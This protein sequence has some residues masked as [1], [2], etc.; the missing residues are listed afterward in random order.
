MTMAGPPPEVEKRRKALLKKPVEFDQNDFFWAK[1]DLP[2]NAT[3]EVSHPYVNQGVF[4]PIRRDEMWDIA[5]NIE[6]YPLTRA[7]ADLAHYVAICFVAAIEYKWW[8]DLFD[9]KG[10]SNYLFTGT[11]CGRNWGNKQTV[12]SGGQKYWVLSNHLGSKNAHD[13]ATVNYGFYTKSKT[14]GESPGK[15]LASLPDWKVKQS[16]GGGHTG[17]HWDYSQ[18]MQ[19]MRNYTVN[20]TVRNMRKALLD[21][22]PLLWDES[23][24]LMEKNLPF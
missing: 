11:S 18:L 17:S 8:S 3:I 7:I 24:K 5:A 21:G 2:G 22:D 10:F 19:F 13:R 16:L 15:Y 4:V 1:L 9:F 12:I 20:G 6:C 23:D 14:E